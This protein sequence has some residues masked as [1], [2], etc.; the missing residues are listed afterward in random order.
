MMAIGCVEADSWL[1]GVQPDVHEKSIL[2]L[3]S[4]ALL[5][6]RAIVHARFCPARFCYCALLS[7]RFCRRG[8]VLRAFVGSPTRDHAYPCSRP[9]CATVAG[10]LSANGYGAESQTNFHAYDLIIEAPR[11]QPIAT[12]W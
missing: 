9:I 5:L 6:P 1:I 4:Y 12:V 8:F 7:A 10:G 3:L 11:V 2:A